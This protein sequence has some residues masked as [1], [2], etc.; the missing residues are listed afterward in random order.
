MKYVTNY[1]IGFLLTSQRAVESIRFACDQIGCELPASWKAKRHLCVG[2]QTHDTATKLLD[3][4]ELLGSECG[5]ADQLGALILK[6]VGPFNNFLRFRK[7][8][9]IFL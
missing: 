8:T 6:G 4:I 3:L 1:F 2:I 7:I 9:L 5:N